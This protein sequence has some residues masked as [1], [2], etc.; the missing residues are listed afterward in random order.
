MCSGRL[1][2][3]CVIHKR[4]KNIVLTSTPKELS[5]SKD[6]LLSESFDTQIETFKV[7]KIIS[8]SVRLASKTKRLHP[9]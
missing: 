3:N 6:E 8:R 1:C 7:R 2:Y 4:K 5:R 9:N